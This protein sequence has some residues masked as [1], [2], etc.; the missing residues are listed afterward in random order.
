[1]AHLLLRA[2]V[3]SYAKWRPGF[4]DNAGARAEAGAGGAAAGDGVTGR[5]RPFVA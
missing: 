4:D 5:R 1:M 3:E 2:K